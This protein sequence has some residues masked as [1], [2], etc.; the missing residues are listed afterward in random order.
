[1]GQFPI[2]KP[3]D[4]FNWADGGGA[5]RTDPGGAK[6][7]LGW[8]FNEKPPYDFFNYMQGVFSDFIEWLNGIATRGFETVDQGIAATTPGEMFRVI[9]E[10]PKSPSD[11]DV[12]MNLVGADEARHTCSDGLHIY[13][14]DKTNDELRA[15]LANPAGALTEAWRVALGVDVIRMKTDGAVVAIGGTLAG[16]NQM[17]VF[18]AATGAVLF[19]FASIKD[20][21]DVAPDSDV[22]SFGAARVFY[23]DGSSIRMWINGVGDV[24]WKNTTGGVRAICTTPDKVLSIEND[25]TGGPNGLLMVSYD[26]TT[27]IGSIIASFPAHPK[28]APAAICSDGE[29]AWAS[30]YH[31][32][33]SGPPLVTMVPTGGLSLSYVAGSPFWSAELLVAGIVVAQ[34]LVRIE[35]D[36]R[37]LYVSGIDEIYILEKMTGA[38]IHR[39][40]SIGSVIFFGYDGTWL[41]KVLTTAPGAIEALGTTRQMGLWLRAG[42]G[43]AVGDNILFGSRRKPF[44]KLALPVR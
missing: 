26:K 25:T 5:V 16:A 40:A 10:L 35:V 43:L 8:L 13:V 21:L 28:G 42:N 6:R 23:S 19:S 4:P 41:Y 17:R 11:G 36:D 29:L 1:M 18:D 15:Y 32:S 14:E 27:V 2:D 22:S 37:F 9:H 20:V 30:L 24:L 34:S 3:T 31:P 38:I 7:D 33:I 39:E 44:L 12:T